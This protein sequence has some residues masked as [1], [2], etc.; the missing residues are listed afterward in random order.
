MIFG[1]F[2]KKKGEEEKGVLIGEVVHYFQHVKAA[3][4]KIRKDKLSIG[5]SIRIKGHTTDFREK[6]VSM[7]IDHEP[8]ESVSKGGEVAIKV[9]KKVRRRDKVYFLK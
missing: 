4:V 1:L 9:K 3:I 7:Q 5:D 2:G 6:I 8:V